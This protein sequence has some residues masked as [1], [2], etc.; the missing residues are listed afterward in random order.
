[1]S[2]F[3]NYAQYIAYPNEYYITR[4]KNVSQLKHILSGLGLMY[5]RLKKADLIEKI[6]SYQSSSAENKEKC[7]LNKS[8]VPALKK[9][10]KELK[11]W[12]CKNKTDYVNAIWEKLNTMRTNEENIERRMVLANKEPKKCKPSSKMLKEENTCG[13]QINFPDNCTN[14]F[15]Y[16]LKCIP[17]EMTWLIYDYYGFSQV[18]E[19]IMPNILNHIQYSFEHPYI[20]RPNW[21][22]ICSRNF[23]GI[24]IQ[25]RNVI[26]W[27]IACQ[28]CNKIRCLIPTTEIYNDKLKKYKFITSNVVQNKNPEYCQCNLS[29]SRHDIPI[30]WY[31]SK[32]E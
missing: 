6:E 16:L 11:I 27:S 13:L 22:K 24:S 9:I 32:N 15:E 2:S 20:I 19:N 14:K 7:F 12:K 1:M 25:Q 4:G 31:A 18:R 23:T 17:K 3:Q 28:L 29:H 30:A 5:S 10:A 8:K 26:K 21:T